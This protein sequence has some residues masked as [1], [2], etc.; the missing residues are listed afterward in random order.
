MF[1]KCPLK[2]NGNKRVSCRCEREDC[3]WWVGIDAQGR[4]LGACA[5]AMIAAGSISDGVVDAVVKAEMIP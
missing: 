1:M 2:F 5:V 4:K 3:E